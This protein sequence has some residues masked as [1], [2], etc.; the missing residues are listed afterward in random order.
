MDE[1][2]KKQVDGAS[3]MT[4][5]ELAQV[6]ETKNPAT[7]KLYT[8]ADLRVFKYESLGTGMLQDA[9]FVRGDWIRNAKNQATARKFLEASFK[10][11]IWCRD[12][13]RDCVNIVLKNGPTLGRGHQT[14]QMN[15]I[16]RLIWPSS[17]GRSDEARR[18]GA[19]GRRRHPGQADH[20]EAD[21]VVPHRPGEGG[22][23]GTAQAGDRRAAGSGSRP[24]SRSRKAGSRTT[25]IETMARREP[26]APAVGG[27]L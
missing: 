26:I 2:L 7:G 13:Y 21:D 3:A 24:W 18:G 4:Y 14:W 25:N 12:H 10:G 9:I 22:G 11:W 19:N 8:L 17:R 27:G 15:E 6:L 1:F 23:G 5:N 20:E 16:N